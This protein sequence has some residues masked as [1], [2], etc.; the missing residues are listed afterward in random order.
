MEKILAA[1]IF[2][3]LVRIEGELAELRRALLKAY[4]AE[5]AKKNPGSLRGIWKGVVIDERDFAEA[6]VSLFPGQDL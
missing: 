3:R 1:G 6:K 4:G 5:V 2:E